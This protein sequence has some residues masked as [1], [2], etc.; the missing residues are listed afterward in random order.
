MLEEQVLDADPS[1]PGK[2]VCQNPQI[3]DKDGSDLRQVPG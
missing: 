2:G 1:G 3:L